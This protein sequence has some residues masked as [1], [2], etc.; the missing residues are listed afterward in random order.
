MK[1]FLKVLIGVSIC[2]Q[3][4]CIGMSVEAKGTDT[5][6]NG[7]YIDRVDVSGMTAAEANDTISLMVEERMQTPITIHC[8]NDND[9]VVTP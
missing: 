6:L 3:L 2:V 5:I 4:C 8:V 9:V 1:K 7:V